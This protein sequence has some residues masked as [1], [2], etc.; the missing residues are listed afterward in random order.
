MEVGG[1]ST[2]YF[3]CFSRTCITL[4]IFIAVVI[5]CIYC[6]CIFCGLRHTHKVK[7][8]SVFLS[9]LSLNSEPCDGLVEFTNK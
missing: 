1:Q 3:Y 8:E 6:V 5:R 4:A 7:H 9:T 2:F